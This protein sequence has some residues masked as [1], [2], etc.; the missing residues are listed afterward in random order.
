MSGGRRPTAPAVGVIPTEASEV[1]RPGS[2]YDIFLHS[3]WADHDRAMVVG[4]TA[5]GPEADFGLARASSAWATSERYERLAA[6]LGF[7]SV[8]VARQAHGSRV[9]S[10][11]PA[12]D[13]GVWI[14]G[15]ADGLACR[16]SGV[17]LCV[18]AADCVP[19]YLSDPVS[20]GMALLHAGW[21]GTA[22]GIMEAGLDH[23]ASRYGSRPESVGIHLGPAICGRCYEVG[24]E[25]LRALAPESEDRTEPVAGGGGAT[26]FVDLRAELAVRARMRGVLVD[27]LTRSPWCTRCSPDQFHSH[28]GMGGSVG[29]MAAF[30]GRRVPRG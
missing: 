20:G 24:E 25:V 30:I 27:H 4:I 3:G 7:E 8:V 13:G 29:R 12:P 28:R 10:V 9:L 17:L 1:R 11:D 6:Q 22:E 2:P 18:T 5:A 14:A 15:A 26:H 21:R 16:R 23:L 19:V